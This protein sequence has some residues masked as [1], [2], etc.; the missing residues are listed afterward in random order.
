M[1]IKG[2]TELTLADQYAGIYWAAP[3]AFRVGVIALA[4]GTAFVLGYEFLSPR[5]NFT[6]VGFVIL[7][8]I[9]CFG[10]VAVGHS[11]LRPE[12][13]RI[14]YLIDRERIVIKDDTGTAFATPWDKVVAIE[15]HASG[16]VLKQRQSGGRW[17]VKRA[18]TP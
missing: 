10:M 14:E 4:A 13:K 9:I 1:I 17:L 8:A 7:F 2:R 16:L 15:E 6:I 11:R 12:Q 5:P 3:R 18:F